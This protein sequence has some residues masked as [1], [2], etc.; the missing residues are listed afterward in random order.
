M[1][2]GFTLIEL[3]IVIGVIGIVAVFTVISVSNARMKSRD[4]RRV[5]Y[6]KQINEA[7]ELYYLHNGI[8]PTA[9]TPG[10]SFVFGSTTYLNIVP[11]NPMPR[12]DGA[13]AT[14]TN[15]SYTP[16]PGN[17][18]FELKFCLGGATNSFPSGTNVIS[19]GGTPT[20][21]R[22]D[23]ISGLLLWLR[24]D[25]LNYNEGDG[26]ATWN[27]TSGNNNHASQLT[28]ANRPIFKTNMLNG[29]PVI[30][31]DGTNDVLT[32][33]SNINTVRTVII[34]EKW[35]SQ[36]KSAAYPI[37]LGH[38]STYDFH[39]STET[40]TNDRIFIGSYTNDFIEAGPVY[41][42]GVS[43]GWTLLYKDRSNFQLI[44]LYPTGNVQFN[45][46]AS[47]RG[48]GFFHGDIAEIIIY[49]AVLTTA[50]R[51]SVERYLKA[52][53]NLTVSGI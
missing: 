36:I 14:D 28:A 35:D 29:K 12:I 38:S 3:I 6:V 25:W 18:D 46:I 49:N 31:F 15:F 30:R 1:K 32:L 48:S 26:V 39:G 22:P 51:Q 9:I 10:Q 2:K 53:Y 5:T 7:L 34:V 40:G 13:C 47:D 45:N 8:Y 11:S 27:D 52:K 50:Q 44:E 42:N 37:L 19:Q 41:N 20:L 33:T 17:H 4:S 21:N 43:V 24:A 16:K 23:A